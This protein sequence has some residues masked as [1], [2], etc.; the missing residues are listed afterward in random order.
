MSMSE[1]WQETVT[2]S[3]ASSTRSFCGIGKSGYP[4]GH[5]VNSP[6]AS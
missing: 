2:R 1:T 5:C 4:T 3:S 6:A